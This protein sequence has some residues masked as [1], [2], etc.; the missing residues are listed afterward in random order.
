MTLVKKRG[1]VK[2]IDD[3]LYPFVKRTA[4]YAGHVLTESK[5]AVDIKHGEHYP[6]VKINAALF[7]ATIVV[8]RLGKLHQ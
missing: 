8:A 1:S 5:V 6:F 7:I 2:I 4:G 3:E